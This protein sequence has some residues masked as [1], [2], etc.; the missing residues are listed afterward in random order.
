MNRVPVLDGMRGIAILLVLWYHFMP[1]IAVPVRAIEWLKKTSTGGWL[2]VELF[3]VLS[4]FL[5]TGILL[6]TKGSPNFY[7]NFYARRILRIFT[8]YYACLAF[9][10]LLLPRFEF[11]S[12]YDL[13][14]LDGAAPWLWAYS[15]NIGWLLQATPRIPWPAEFTDLRH[16]WSLAIEEHF[17]L[18]WPLVVATANLRQLKRLCCVLFGFSLLSRAIWIALVSNDSLMIFQTPFLLDPLAAGAF[19]AVAARDGSWTRVLPYAKAIGLAS[20]IPL[21]AFFFT[22]KG[23]WASHWLMQTFG[24]GAA[25]IVFASGIMLAVEG[26]S[27][28]AISRIIDNPMLRFFGKYSYGLYVTH[29]IVVGALG[30]WVSVPRF[31]VATGSESLAVVCIIGIKLGASVVVAVLSWHLLEKHFLKLKS[32]FSVS[33]DAY[34]RRAAVY[35]PRHY[36][37]GNS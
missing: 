3:F 36:T 30:D 27:L 4:G 10:L 18:V 31:L 2:G 17:Y 11:H 26:G 13:D 22:M 23:L 32:Q 24:I 6:N 28:S 19:I 5:I 9:V 20:L 15:A 1:E 7:R 8:L 14:R 34:S 21:I 29:P 16:F 35:G 37:R 12:A 33:A 25:S